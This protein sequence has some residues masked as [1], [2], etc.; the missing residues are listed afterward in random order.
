MVLNFSGRRY[1]PAHEGQDGLLT[2]ADYAL[3]HGGLGDL[4][5][6]EAAA[7]V[8]IAAATVTQ[9]AGPLTLTAGTWL[10]WGFVSFLQGAA[11]GTCEA[12]LRQGTTR[13]GEVALWTL[14]AAERGAGP[15]PMVGVVVGADTTYN[16]AAFCSAAATARNDTPAFSAGM[17]GIR[18][19]RVG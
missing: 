18:A 15:V 4:T 7:D 11:A 12:Y 6:D 19:V 9:I 14:A 13:V 3:L 10:V 1:Y 17:T 16:L 2:A 5:D 8:A